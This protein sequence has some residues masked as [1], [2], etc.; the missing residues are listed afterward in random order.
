[1]RN[2]GGNEVGRVRKVR[3]GNGHEMG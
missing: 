3:T 2:E 1:M